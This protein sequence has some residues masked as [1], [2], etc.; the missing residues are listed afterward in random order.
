MGTRNAGSDNDSY[1]D[2]VFLKLNLHGIICEEAVLSSS[3]IPIKTPPPF[4]LP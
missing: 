1:F 2:E 4:N 3:K